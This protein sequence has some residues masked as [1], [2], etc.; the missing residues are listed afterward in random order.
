MA[1]GCLSQCDCRIE[2][3]LNINVTGSG[4]DGDPYVIATSEQTFAASSP[5]G[6]IDITAGGTAGHTP[7][8]DVRIDPT[9]TATPS[10]TVDGLKFDCC[11]GSAPVLFT[12]TLTGPTTHTADEDTESVFL[13]DSTAGA[14]T[15]SLPNGVPGGTSF[16]VKD[17][18]G[19]ALSNSITIDTVGAPTIDGAAS[20]ALDI[21]FQSI[22]VISDGSNWYII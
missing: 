6:T 11:V 20:L 13:V 2:G 17:K 5:N 19:T 21:P 7:G 22:T 12:S 9:G 1:C 4:Q 16:T 18:F 3:S 15:V 8:F 10:V 14:V